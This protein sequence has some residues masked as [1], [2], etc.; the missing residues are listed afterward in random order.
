MFSSFLP[1]FVAVVLKTIGGLTGLAAAVAAWRAARLWLEASKIPIEYAEPAVQVSYDDVP[2]LGIL[3]AKVGVDAAQ[4]AYK[5][6]AALNAEAARWTAW[7]A[8][9]TGASA[10]LAVI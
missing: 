4:T 2:A 8:I 5:K 9:L 6:S 7:A 3:D 10:L 1:P